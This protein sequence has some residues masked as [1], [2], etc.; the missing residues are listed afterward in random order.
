M[1]HSASSSTSI[2]FMWCHWMSQLRT[3]CCVMSS[4]LYRDITEFTGAPVGASKDKGKTRNV[5]GKSFTEKAEHF[6][7]RPSS[8]VLRPAGDFSWLFFLLIASWL[9]GFPATLPTPDV[10]PKTR[11]ALTVIICCKWSRTD[12]ELLQQN[13]QREHY[14]W[15]LR[16][17]T[18]TEGY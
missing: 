18:E 5:G 12:Q 10:A 1:T 16:V 17:S 7:Q 3:S 2:C 9:C 4:P 13:H 11:P 6:T 14:T 8:A 15:P